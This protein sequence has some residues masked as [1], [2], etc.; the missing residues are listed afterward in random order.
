VFS[1]SQRANSVKGK[2]GLTTEHNNIT[3]LELQP[4]F[5]GGSNSATKGE[6]DW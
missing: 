5:R 2:A 6:G 1:G 3:M 4:A